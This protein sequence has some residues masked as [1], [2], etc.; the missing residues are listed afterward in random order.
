MNNDVILEARDLTK[1]YA[2][3]PRRERR[4]ADGASRHHPCADRAERRRQDDLLQSAHEVSAAHAR[5]A[6]CSRAARSP[7]LRRPMSRGWASCARSRSPRSS[8]ISRCSRTC[9]SRCSASAAP[10]STSGAPRARSTP[11][12]RG[13]W[14]CWRPS[15]WR[16]LASLPAVELPYGRKRALEI[17]TTL[18]L[19]PEMMLLDEPTAGM[20]HEDIDRIAAADQARRGQPHR[21]DGRAQSQRRRRAVGPHHR[22]GARRDPGRG[23][24]RDGRRTTRR[25]SRPIWELAMAELLSRTPQRRCACSRST[26]CRPGT[27]KSHILHGVDFDI[28]R[29][30]S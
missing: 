24:L 8:R 17:A 23:R 9:A 3:L 22:A 29:A 4:E 25:C 12:T 2:G 19:D 5:A 6:S 30:R 11:T 27:A 13:R 20:G 14:S 15:A 10:R 16:T 26:A 7:R 1:D 21:A 18:A 28:G